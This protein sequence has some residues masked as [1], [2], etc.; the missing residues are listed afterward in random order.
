MRQRKR[1][2][3]ALV[4]AAVLAVGAFVR[5]EDPDKIGPYKQLTTI[6]IPG[7]G[8]GFDISWV[9]S[10]AG[11]YYLA[12]R[13][14]PPGVPARIDVID[15]QSL[16]LLD[17]LHVNSAGNGIAAIRVRHDG[18]LQ[19][20]NVSNEL[21]VG[22]ANSHVEVIDLASGSIVGD[23]DTLGQHRADELAYDPIDGILIVANDQ[24]SPPFVTFIS[25]ETR[26]SLGPLSFPQSTGGLEQP[27]FNQQTK[28]FYLAIPST[29]KNPQGEVDEIDPLNQV[30]TRVF[31]DVCN[32]GAHP[33]GLVLVPR[34]RLVTSCGDIIDISDPDNPTVTTVPGLSGDEIWY[35]PGD[36][37]VYFG[38]FLAVPVLDIETNTV[39][40][41]LPV[42]PGHFTHSVAADSETNRIFIPISSAGVEVFTDSAEK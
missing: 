14:N 11:R 10:E 31:P 8:F 27:V 6:P 35:N 15:T 1:W 34:Q 22:E 23:I 37:R 5:A 28:M 17:P 26:S 7:L 4:V 33:Q 38:T 32:A 3:P 19:E 40:A 12:D 29:K 39:V 36:K 20:G 24:D 2:M 9:D 25:T 30:V 18:D 16:T 13:G 41:V 42:T 21:W